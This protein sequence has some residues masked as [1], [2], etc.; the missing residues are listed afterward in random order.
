[1]RVCFQSYVPRAILGT[2]V[3]CT[4]IA[5]ALTA[6]GHEH[7]G[8]NPVY[9]FG[10]NLVYSLCIGFITYAAIDLPR[11]RL[12][13]RSKASLV[14]MVGL[15]LF[16][17]PV[18]WFGGNFIASLLLGLP[19]NPG[20]MGPNAMLGFLA[21]T[22]G[23]GLSGTFYFWT[24]EQLAD[25]ER[26]AAEARLKLLQAQIEPHFLFNTLANLQALIGSDPARAQAMLGHLDAYLRATLA[27]TRKDHG[28]LAEEFALLRG[29]LE[30][31]AI[32]MGPRLSYTLD[33]PH[34]LTAARVPPML[35]QPLV[36]NAIK[37]GLEPKING[38]KL[39][40][41]AS[42]EGKQ[43]VL[44]VEDDGLGFG[45]A[46]TSGTGVGLE[47]VKERLAAVYGEAAKA[48]IGEN[49]GGGVRIVLRMPL[50]SET[51]R[52]DTSPRAPLGQAAR[53]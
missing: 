18:G 8:N 45:A 37:H 53:K 12:W 24:R 50:E 27:S 20:A 10:I 51:K 41:A 46:S 33:L 15:A 11:R 14:P 17:A 35:L 28:T 29:Y 52:G 40:V 3:L 26:V 42:A 9:N 38:G 49:A 44:V 43:L 4:L 34:A 21:L 2:I 7:F 47:H 6:F 5:V 30:I 48:E 39:R 32:R 36:E 1:M 16:A 25:N 23:A 13:R 19:W 22:A 31:L